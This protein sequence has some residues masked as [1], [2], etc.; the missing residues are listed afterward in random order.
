MIDIDKDGII[1]CIT[2]KDL[3]DEREY[4]EELFINPNNY[5]GYVEIFDDDEMYVELRMKDFLELC[6]YMIDTFGGI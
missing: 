5:G 2:V 1:S 3:G 4:I 6:Q